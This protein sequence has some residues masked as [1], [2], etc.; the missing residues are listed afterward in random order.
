MVT[1]S[2]KQAKTGLLH[3]LQMETTGEVSPAGSREGAQ[4]YRVDAF[5]PV[6]IARAHVSAPGTSFR[7]HL[8]Y[9]DGM[10]IDTGPRRL[11]GL[12]RTFFSSLPHVEY[13]V[14]TH[15]HEDH[16]GMASHAAA[17][18]I[19]VLC[20]PDSVSAASRPF[21][22]PFYRRAFWRS[23]KPFAAKPLPDKVQTAHYTFDVIATPGHTPEHVALY[24]REQGWLFSG[25]L[26]LG[27][28]VM[29][30][31]REESLPTLMA[32]LRKVL[33]LDF[34]TMFCAHVGP[35]DDGKAALRAKLQYLEDL[36]GRVRQL[37]ERGLTVRQATKQ[38][39]PKLQM[40][41]VLSGGEFSP[42][43]VVHS[44]WPD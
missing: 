20:H 37:A 34:D 43:H 27:T 40:M 5:G 41:T 16:S 21:S 13:V 35:V 26:Y 1:Y 22:L 8:Y 44:L 19:P 10:L 29:T 4:L 38:I 7:V 17:A 9:V 6:K 14:L 42:L 3:L 23:P 28:R 33:A 12:F 11:A 32:S 24:E 2:M 15:L 18:G 31:M 39:Y 25:D 36:Q 30:A